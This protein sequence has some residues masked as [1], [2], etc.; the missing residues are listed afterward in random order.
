MLRFEGLAVKTIVQPQDELDENTEVVTNLF[1][2]VEKSNRTRHTDNE[3]DSIG[4][5]HVQNTVNGQ[6]VGWE[7]CR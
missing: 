7:R 1:G 4:S 2:G 6:M 3:K 5:A